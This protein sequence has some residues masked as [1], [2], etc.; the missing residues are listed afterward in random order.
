MGGSIIIILYIWVSV[1]QVYRCQ[2]CIYGSVWAKT[3]YVNTVYMGQCGQVY[4]C[5]YCTMYIY[6]GQCGPSLQMSIYLGQCGPSLQMSI[7]MGQC[8][9]SLY[10]CQY[11]WVS[12]GQVYW[13]QYIWVSVGQ[14]YWCQHIWVSVGQVYTDVNIFGS[15]LTAPPVDKYDRADSSSLEL[16]L[17]DP[18]HT[19]RVGYPFFSKERNVLAFF[20]IL[21]KRTECFLRSFPF[22]IKEQNVFCV[23]FRS[24]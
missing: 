17:T 5:Q 15:A 20:S 16:N 2:Y 6:M 1:G 3:K 22:F 18:C 7:Y 8:G 12:V 23:L 9:P 10:R 21:Y 11:I 24:L 4:R 19:F 14:V 13:C